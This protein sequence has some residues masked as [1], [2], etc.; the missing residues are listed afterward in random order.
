MAD[1]CFRAEAN[2][3]LAL[4]PAA[5]DAELTKLP[6]R[7]RC[8]LDMEMHSVRTTLAT[9]NLNPEMK[10]LTIYLYV[11]A[12]GDPDTGI[13]SATWTIE[14]IELFDG[15]E[16]RE[17]VREAFKSAFTTLTNKPVSITFSDEYRNH[18]PTHTPG[19]DYD[20]DGPTPGA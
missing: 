5:R 8:A 11:V 7:I 4:S 10:T 12:N 9:F 1:D 16:H 15:D 2:R 3:L 17:A 14:D 18:V 6:E 13:V 19:P 20:D